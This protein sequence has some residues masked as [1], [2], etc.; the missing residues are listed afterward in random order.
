M[1]ERRAE[2]FSEEGAERLNRT[3]L[4]Q[5]NRFKFILLGVWIVLVLPGNGCS[6]QNI[7]GKYNHMARKARR[8]FLC[9]IFSISFLKSG[10]GVGGE[11]PLPIDIWG[12]SYP[13]EYAPGYE[14]PFY[15]KLNV[16]QE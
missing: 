1:L 9:F 8:N 16:Y 5:R 14:Y 15:I 10:G 6:I 13:P 4:D 11:G 2:P 3:A 12:F 7:Y